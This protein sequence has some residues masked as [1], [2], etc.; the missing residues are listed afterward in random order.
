MTPFLRLAE[1]WSRDHL[2]SSFS[3]VTSQACIFTLNVMWGDSESASKNTSVPTFKYQKYAKIRIFENLLAI[4]L[5]RLIHKGRPQKRGR[6]SGKSGRPKIA[7]AG[8]GVKMS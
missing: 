6:D 5:A 1:H 7:D 8:E 4:D 3:L 2:K